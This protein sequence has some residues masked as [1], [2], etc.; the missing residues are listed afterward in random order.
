VAL[1]EPGTWFD[2]R[3]YYSSVCRFFVI[4]NYFKSFN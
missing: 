1:P 4:S 2:F 3:Q